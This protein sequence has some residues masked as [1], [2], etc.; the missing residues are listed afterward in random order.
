MVAR[1]FSRTNHR[2]KWSK[3]KALSDYFR[4]TVLKY[5]YIDTITQWPAAYLIPFYIPRKSD[6]TWPLGQFTCHIDDDTNVGGSIVSIAFP[7]EILPSVALLHIFQFQSSLS[8]RVTRWQV[9][10]RMFD[11]H[12][13]FCYILRNCRSWIYLKP[14][15]ITVMIPTADYCDALIYLQRTTNTGRFGFNVN[16]YLKVCKGNMRKK[17]P[18]V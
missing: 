9:F 4:Y 11:H 7:A 14:L 6:R 1:V 16:M 17:N 10:W 15:H 13:C 18:W 8:S 2:M 3:T 12:R 5:C